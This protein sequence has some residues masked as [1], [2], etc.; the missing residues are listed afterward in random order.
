TP[1]QGPDGAGSTGPDADNVPPS[2]G[3]DDG[4][5]SVFDATGPGNPD[6]DSP[7]SPDAGGTPPGTDASQPIDSGSQDTGSGVPDSSTPPPTGSCAGL[8]STPLF[9]DDFDE[10]T[11]LAAPW[12][13]LTTTGGSE[14]VNSA[15]S[16]SSPHSMLV[17]VNSNQSDNSIDL[18][19]Y[20]SFPAKQ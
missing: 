17:T 19:G 4:G 10:S 6:A 3:G 15:S 1:V 20:K 14:A 18:A 9:C 13:Q 12:D 2:G 7:G 11:A 16:V 5:T 8:G